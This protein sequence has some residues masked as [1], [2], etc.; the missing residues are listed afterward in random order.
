[1]DERPQRLALTGHAAQIVPP[2]LDPSSIAQHYRHR[3]VTGAAAAVQSN[4][5]LAK[6]DLHQRRLIAP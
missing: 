3:F 1:V 2:N 6:I 5:R 4:S